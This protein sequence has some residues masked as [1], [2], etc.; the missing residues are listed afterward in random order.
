MDK[1]TAIKVLERYFSQ[2]DGHGLRLETIA[3]AFKVSE[4]DVRKVVDEY[5]ETIQNVFAMY[6]QVSHQ[7]S[8]AKQSKIGFIDAII[9][10]QNNNQRMVS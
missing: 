3:R 2:V 5:Y 7:N 1:V 10:A 9:G 8:Y 4:S 6:W